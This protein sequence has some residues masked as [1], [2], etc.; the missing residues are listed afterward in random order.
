MPLENDLQACPPLPNVHLDAL[1]P[2]PALATTCSNGYGIDGMAVCTALGLLATSNREDN[3]LIVF[4]LPSSLDS[5]SDA[6]AGLPL[7]C[8]LGGASSPTPMRFRFQDGSGSSESGRMAATARLLL[9]TDAGH[10]AVHVIDIVGRAHV[11]YVAAPG[12]IA[13]PRGVA[14]RG[15]LVAVSA[16]KH[17]GCGD[18]LVRLFEGSGAT[19]RAARVVGGGVGG[20]GS[21]DGQL[22]RPFGLRFSA[23]GT[24]LAVADASNQGSRAGARPGARLGSSTVPGTLAHDY[25]THTNEQQRSLANGVRE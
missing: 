14:A 10:D 3:T 18:H 11:G 2:L 19:W 16:W 1:V 22:H 23:D 24:G 20:L 4:A 9:V 15:S 5:I 7:V 13:G 6:G 12:T 21:A 8:T 17:G 25:D